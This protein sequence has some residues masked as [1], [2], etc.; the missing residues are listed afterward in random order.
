MA[1]L[2][3]VPWL[4]WVLQE[5]FMT[6]VPKSQPDHPPAKDPA[7]LAREA[8][9]R[10]RE[11]ARQRGAQRISPKTAQRRRAQ[12]SAAT[13]AEVSPVPFGS[14]RDPKP[15]AEALNSMLRRMGWSEHIEVASVTARWREVMGDQI[16]DHCEPLSFDDGVLVVR[17]S[18]SAW[19]TQLTLMQGQVKHRL[20]EE[21][22]R[23]VVKEL[24]FVGPTARS[25]VKGPRR[26]KG[27]GPRD[28]YG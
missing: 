5:K 25:W 15:M 3:W 10:A 2:A 27:R 16:A 4:T 19:A 1:W 12:K 21:F 13:D 28:T 9:E 11:S 24:H 20:N 18:S 14:G 26:V 23:E 6:D 17:A 7:A 8:M 22:G